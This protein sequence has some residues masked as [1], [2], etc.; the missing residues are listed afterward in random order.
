MF[1]DVA[2]INS[3]LIGLLPALWTIFYYRRN[4]RRGV[5]F[6]PMMVGQILF[7]VVVAPPMLFASYYNLYP[8]FYP[9]VIFCLAFFALWIGYLVLGNVK[10]ELPVSAN[11]TYSRYVAK[12]GQSA[13]LFAVVGLVV[14]LIGLGINYYDGLPLTLRSLIATVTGNVGEVTRELQLTRLELT[15]GAYFGGE[16]RG[17]GVNTALQELGWSLVVAH[18]AAQMAFRRNAKT[19]LWLM[20]TVF[21]AWLFVAGTGTRAP[22]MLCLVSGL[23]AYSQVEAVRPRMLIVFAVLMIGILIFL[24]SYT[25]RFEDVVAGQAGWADAVQRIIDRLVLEGNGTAD[26]QAILASDTGRIDEGFAHF[27]IRDFVSAIPGVQGAMPLA[28]HITDLYGGGATT[29]RSGTYI[30]SA[31]VDFGLAGVMVAFALIGLIFRVLQNSILPARV[32]PWSIAVAAVIVMCS[33]KLV[34]NGWAEFFAYILLLTVFLVVHLIL[35]V[36]APIKSK[37]T[38]RMP[39]QRPG[40][41]GAAR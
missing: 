4:L 28:A 5:V 39:Q 36:A 35:L 20:A 16:D 12:R 2:L 10:L 3:L 1:S 33:L 30:S 37:A 7:W 14:L 25:H 21:G 9:A 27:L 13:H 24:T 8:G 18:A 11:G 26:V 41:P 22:F 38:V 40:L 17:Q 15:K 6:T 32:H 29:F 34:F 31:Y 19:I 23:I